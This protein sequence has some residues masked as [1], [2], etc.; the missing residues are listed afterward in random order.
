MRNGLRTVTV[1]ILA[2]PENAPGQTGEQG[3]EKDASAVHSSG[4]SPLRRRRLLRGSPRSEGRCYTQ[5]RELLRLWKRL[6]LCLTHTNWGETLTNAGA[7][8]QG[9]GHQP[10]SNSE[11]SRF[12]EHETKAGFHFSADLPRPEP[13]SG[14]DRQPW[15]LEG[16]YALSTR[17]RRRDQQQWLG[18]TFLRRTNGRQLPASRL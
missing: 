6:I 18:R 15:C 17:F 1:L 3:G 12:Y 5:K 2:G 16:Q 9:A 8:T 7:A 14:C 10:W 4:L 13:A 11:A